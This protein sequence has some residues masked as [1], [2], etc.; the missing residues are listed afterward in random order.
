M[1]V[2]DPLGLNINIGLDE[3]EQ[4]KINIADN[5]ALTPQEV[6]SLIIENVLLCK[7]REAFNY[8]I[9]QDILLLNILSCCN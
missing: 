7:K 9:L 2:F 5:V 4:K 6:S 8:K 3:E 1:E